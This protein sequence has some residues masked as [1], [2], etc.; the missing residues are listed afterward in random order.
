MAW[1]YFNI[2]TGHLER[3]QHRTSFLGLIAERGGNLKQLLSAGLKGWFNCC[4]S[5][6]TALLQ[7][8]EPQHSDLRT[9]SMFSAPV[10]LAEV[11]VWR[12][13]FLV[14]VSLLP[15]PW[16]QKEGFLGLPWA[17]GCKKDK[18]HLQLCFSEQVSSREGPKEVK[19]YLGGKGAGR[20]GK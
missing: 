15:Y 14:S 18:C 17:T 6:W 4:T 9:G 16:L 1:D 13:T 5:S 20:E 7:H 12:F 10:A 19:S 2:F 3:R 8:A 11:F